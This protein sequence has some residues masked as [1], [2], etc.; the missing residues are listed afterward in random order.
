[1]NSLHIIGNLTAD[2][3][4]RTTTGGVDV[5]SFN[6]AVNRRKKADSQET[7]YFHVTAWKERGKTCAQYLKKGSKVS[8]VGP[9]SV[10]TYTGNDGT[11]K[12][13]MDVTAD[14]VEF[15]SN[16]S[17]SSGYTQVEIQDNPFI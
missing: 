14:D 15:L 7:D 1:M 17:E 9:V 13:S 8:V 11:T 4:L 2:P 3:E 6:V 5:C 10:R 12:A 16:R